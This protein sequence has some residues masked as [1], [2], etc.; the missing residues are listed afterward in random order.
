[1]ME[2]EKENRGFDQETSDELE[3]MSEK[4]FLSYSEPH[5]GESKIKINGGSDSGSGSGLLLLRVCD[6]CG[7]H[8]NSGKALGGHRRHHILAQKNME[9]QNQAHLA[10]AEHLNNGSSSWSTLE[11][12]S[13]P[14]QVDLSSSCSGSS[15][16]KKDKRGRKI[17]GETEASQIA[18]ETLMYMHLYGNYHLRH[19]LPPRD[20]PTPD[21]AASLSVKKRKSNMMNHVGGSSSLPSGKQKEKSEG[22]DGNEEL[23]A[24][25]NMC[26]WVVKVISLI[27]EKKE[28]IRTSK[29]KEVK[30]SKSYA[31]N[32]CNKSFPCFQA[33]GGHKTKHNRGKNIAKS[34]K[35]KEVVEQRQEEEENK[36]GIN[37]SSLISSEE[38]FVISSKNHE[39]N[40][41]KE[42]WERQVNNRVRK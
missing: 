6:F 13:P 14:V 8:F 38:R 12:S 26:M 7:K 25:N 31:C 3:K 30:P 39:N 28:M 9:A 32:V 1:M 36:V 5:E 20:E 19:R 41:N 23:N 21:E 22:S 11:E 27:K 10:S 33:L 34:T 24:E 16:L 15:W 2:D 4:T 42:K 37:G 17:I 40:S 29:Q 18:A 35:G